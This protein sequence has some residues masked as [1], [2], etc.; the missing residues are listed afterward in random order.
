MPSMTSY[1]FSFWRLPVVF[2]KRVA[3]RRVHA[4]QFSEEFGRFP[5]RA[6]V[7]DQKSAVRGRVRAVS[8]VHCRNKKIDM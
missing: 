2:D 5:L 6:V 3:R 7:Q 4:L 1:S 8:L